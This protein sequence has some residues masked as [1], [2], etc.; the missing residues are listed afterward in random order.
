MDFEGNSRISEFR[1]NREFVKKINSGDFT[2][3]SGLDQTRASID[4]LRESLNGNSPER[5]EGAGY[6]N[7]K[8][9]IRNFLDDVG[10]G[11]V[12]F[13]N[14]SVGD[15]F[16]SGINTEKSNTRKAELQ[17]RQ[18]D[19]GNEIKE[20]EVK[21]RAEKNSNKKAEL[22]DSL[23]NKTQTLDAINY[24]LHLLYGEDYIGVD[25]SSLYK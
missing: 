25:T 23:I 12:G 2:D 20:L 21:Y 8:F 18:E 5:K 22:K 14:D 24:Q 11:R 17:K 6:S 16:F 3:S 10:I 19:F 15:K 13:Q 1:S 9:S 4:K 7:G